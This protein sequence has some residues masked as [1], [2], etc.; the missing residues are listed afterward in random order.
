M[1]TA[2]V[3]NMAEEYICTLDETYLNI[4]RKELN[5]DPRNRLGAVKKLRE[6]VEGQPHISYPTG[7]LASCRMR[8][9]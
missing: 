4:A 8:P 7:K 9:T 2:K 6:W 5:E 1:A 3:S